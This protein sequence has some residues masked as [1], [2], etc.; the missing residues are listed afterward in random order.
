M[1]VEKTIRENVDFLSHVFNTHPANRVGLVK[2]S[3]GIC[4]KDCETLFG[5]FLSTKFK[6][7]KAKKET[8]RVALDVE[9]LRG[10]GA[11]ISKKDLSISIPYGAKLNGS[12]LGSL[13][14]LE[15]FG[16]TV[17]RA[18]YRVNSENSFECSMCSSEKVA[19]KFKTDIEA[20][21]D[22]R[23]FICEDCYIQMN[24]EA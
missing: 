22:E 24:G 6:G 16:Y 4:E 9:I 13:E 3:L 21:Q 23:D 2:D 12:A 10:A 14:K 17:I 19:E 11:N 7:Y 15:R 8:K 20:G 5:I 1:N 18:T